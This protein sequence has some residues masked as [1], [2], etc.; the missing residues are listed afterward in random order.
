[1]LNDIRLMLSTGA[2]AEQ[3]KLKREM[4]GDTQFWSVQ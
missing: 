2:N 3:R 1:L 4:R